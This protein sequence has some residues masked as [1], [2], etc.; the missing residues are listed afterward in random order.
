[1]KC[2]TL[3]NLLIIPNIQ[4]HPDY[5]CSVQRSP[6][7]VL[8]ILYATVLITEI[9]GYLM[10]QYSWIYRGRVEG[11]GQFT[12]ES[13][14]MEQR[15]RQRQNETFSVFRDAMTLADDAVYRC[16]PNEHVEGQTYLRITRLAEGMIQKRDI[17][18]EVCE[19]GNHCRGVVDNCERL[20]GQW[21]P[22]RVCISVNIRKRVAVG[23]LPKVLSGAT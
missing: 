16:D 18:D 20:R 3:C 2:E 22:I 11:V 4:D 21:T 10:M 23:N 12:R 8:Y 1:M 14:L 9:K 13:K 19:D 5:V 7:Q 6:K 17:F 15:F